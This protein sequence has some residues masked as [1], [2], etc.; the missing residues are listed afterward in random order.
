MSTL[1]T[2]KPAQDRTEKSTLFSRLKRGLQSTQAVLFSDINDLFS[3]NKEIDQ[4]LLDQLEE[5]L[6]SAD[7][8]VTA[9][10]CILESLAMR[11]KN[12]AAANAIPPQQTLR[13]ILLEILS[14]IERP[15][16]IPRGGT[17]P[18]VILVTGVNGSGKTTSI[19]KLARY[20]KEKGYSV[21]LAAGDTFR[22]AAIEQLQTWGK[23]NMCR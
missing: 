17:K 8:G 10:R 19:G 22:A 15:L 2:G 16:K 14:R 6:L 21:M 3:G 12:S 20:F 18:F 1:D 9:T 5:R 4:A 11:R 13:S 7:V 23:K